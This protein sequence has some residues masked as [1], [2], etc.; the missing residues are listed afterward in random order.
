[1]PV[2]ART[3]CVQV[4]FWV[5]FRVRFRVRPRVRF[6][7]RFRIRF[8]VRFRVYPVLAFRFQ[9]EDFRGCNSNAR[10]CAYSL[11]PGMVSGAVS[12]TVAGTV[13]GTAS[14]VAGFGFR[15][16]GS[17][18]EELQES[19]CVLVRLG[20]G[21]GFG[22]DFGYSFGYIRVSCISG[23]RFWGCG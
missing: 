1:M 13:S 21:N 9:V 7:V 4:C 16:S 23:F 18:V 20:F 14:G 15:M 19:Q 22:F 6:R 5:R 11:L 2:C 10:V 3:T 12:G 17:R 8:R